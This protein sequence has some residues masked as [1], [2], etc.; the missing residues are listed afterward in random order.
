MRIQQAYFERLMSDGVTVVGGRLKVMF[1]PTDFTLT[2]A[3]QLGEVAIP[4]LETPLQQ[5]VRGQ[6]EKLTVKLFF[7][8]TDE[9]TDDLASGVVDKTDRFYALVKIDGE[10]HAPPVCRFVWG[11]S[12]PGSQMPPDQNRNNLNRGAFTGVVEQVQQE[13]TLF[14]PTG[15]PLR[16]NLTITMREYKTLAQQVSELKWASRDRTRTYVVRRGDTLSAIAGRLYDNPADWRF[17]ADANG[18]QNPR[19]LVPGTV[20][21][22][23][24]IRPGTSIAR[25]RPSLAGPAA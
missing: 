16:A 20:L 3:S 4:G 25:A 21:D 23:P 5:F 18:L 12:F 14:S 2:K 7:D 24:P 17:I 9:R 13:F 15:V 10:T 6:A 1:N 11:P 22:I 8:G 19:R